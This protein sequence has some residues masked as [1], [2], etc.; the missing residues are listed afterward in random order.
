MMRVAVIAQVEPQH[1][2]APLEQLLAQR[3]EVQ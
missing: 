2:E 3:E 1:V